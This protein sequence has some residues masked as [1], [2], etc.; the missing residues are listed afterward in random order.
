MEDERQGSGRVQE[1]AQGVLDQLEVPKRIVL[2]TTILVDHLRSRKKPSTLTRL[3]DKADLATTMINLFE[4]YY[5][6]CKSGDVKRN[7]TAVKGLRS[8][9]QLLS[10]TD[11]SAEQAGQILAQLE[12]KGKPLEARDLFVGAIA[13]EEGYA[14]LTA[15]VEHFRRIPDLQVISE[16][17]LTAE[18]ST[19]PSNT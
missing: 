19:T 7:L 8:T 13:L 4:L 5:G 15:N 6:A 17:E 1:G 14:I 2:D 18:P 16:R 11:G 9:L 3:E 12:A 10:L